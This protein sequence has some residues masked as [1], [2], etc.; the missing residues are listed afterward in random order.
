[1]PNSHNKPTHGYGWVFYDEHCPK[2]CGWEGRF[3][4]VLLR[5]HILTAPL[6]RGWVQERLELDANEAFTEMRVLTASGKVLGGAAAMVYLAERIWF[7][8]PLAAVAKLPG[9]MGQLHR[10]YRYIAHHRYCQT[11]NCKVAKPQHKQSHSKLRSEPR[12][13]AGR[14]A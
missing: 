3:K 10:L 9:V 12:H 7:A 11:T 1:M 2:C 6:Q 5:R 13:E 4:K 8:K 14:A